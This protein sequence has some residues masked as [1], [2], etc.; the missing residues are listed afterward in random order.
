MRF[1]ALCLIALGIGGG[2]AYLRPEPLLREL[3]PCMPVLIYPQTGD[4]P[5]DTWFVESVF[6]DFAIARRGGEV[7]KITE[8]DR[9]RVI[10]ITMSGD[11]YAA[12]TCERPRLYG[13]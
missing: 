11:S 3:K 7:R 1:A 2:Y 5:P 8:G 12:Q 13:V 9:D 6:K 4:G 10:T